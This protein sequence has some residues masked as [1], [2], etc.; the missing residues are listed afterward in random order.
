MKCSH[1]ISLLGSLFVIFSIEAKP[2]SKD[3]IISLGKDLRER[4]YP[5]ANKQALFEDENTSFLK[6]SEDE[7]ARITEVAHEEFKRCG[8]FMLHQEEEE[9]VQFW[10]ERGLAFAAQKMLPLNYQINQES[11]V[12]NFISQ[13][14]EDRIAQVI[15]KLSSYK[16]RF[17]TSDTGVESQLW[18]F[19]HWKQLSHNRNDV[20]VF[21]WKHNGWPQDSIV[22]EITGKSSDKIIVGGHGD[23]VSGW[24]R[25][26]SATAP[27]ADDNAS[28]IATITEIIKVLLDGNYQPQNTLVF[29]S[30]AAEEVGLLGSKE[31]AKSY[32]ES[33]ENVLGVLQLDMTNFN[34]SDWDIVLISDYT[35]EAQNNFLGSLIDTYLPQLSWG[36]DKCGYACSDHASWTAQGFPASTPFEARKGDMN[37][38]IHTSRDTLSRSNDNANHARKFAKLGVAYVVELDN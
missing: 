10:H 16:N 24:W 38:H 32:R 1:L 22:M 37:G 19:N 17:Y 5:A 31:M 18:L 23:S 9:A 25:R 11:T 30:Y 35:N 36:Y 7:L 33:G 8:G 26:E 13:V 12:K 34:G 28:G 21:R 20:N 3:V 4:I 6:V 27:G 14:Q 29:V 15:R 2:Q